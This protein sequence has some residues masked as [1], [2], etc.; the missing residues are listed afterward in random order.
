M[1]YSA[2]GDRIPA[3]RIPDPL[4]L[5]SP[6]AAAASSTEPLGRYLKPKKAGDAAAVKVARFV[7][8]YEVEN[9]FAGPIDD[10]SIAA[11]E[12]G[13]SLRGGDALIVSGYSG[14]VEWLLAGL[15]VRLGTPI[16]RIAYDSAGVTV[17]GASAEEA[18]ERVIVTVPLGVLKAG[19]IEF[20]PPLPAAKAAAISRLGMGVVDKVYLQFDEVFWD[21]DAEFIG[22][23]A[24][25]GG[26]FVLWLNLFP[27]AAKPILV[28]FNAA[29]YADRLERD[30]DE[31]IVDAALGTLRAIYG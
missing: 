16:E 13:R 9:E 3:K 30:S 25:D 11:I 15:E 31:E 8:S 18:A 24:P 7:A 22:Y 2:N 20:A 19:T 4:A 26:S 21:R 23:V 10:L 1:V 29:D 14:I 27:Y 5:V 6:A 12:E 17:A 28:A